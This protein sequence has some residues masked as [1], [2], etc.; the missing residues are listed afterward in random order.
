MKMINGY[1]MV[2]AFALN[3]E[4][5]EEFQG[6]PDDIVISTFPKSGEFCV[7]KNADLTL[8]FVYKIVLDFILL[9]FF[10]LFY[11]PTT[12]S[13]SSSA[14]ISFLGDSHLSPSPFTPLLPHSERGKPPMV[15]TKAWHIKLR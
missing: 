14:P 12:V 6:R 3:W 2:Y 8:T 13:P 11:T 9:T 15:L 4:R 1:P 10:H 5:M 7:L